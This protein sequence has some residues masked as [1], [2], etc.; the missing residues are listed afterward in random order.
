[1]CMKAVAE[2]IE[3]AE[4]KGNPSRTLS[5]S[6]PSRNPFKWIVPLNLIDPEGANFQGRCMRDLS[7]HHALQPR[8]GNARNVPDHIDPVG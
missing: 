4:K 6:R 8:N 5:S 3:F 7:R 2:L 1:M